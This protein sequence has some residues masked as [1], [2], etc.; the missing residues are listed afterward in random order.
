MGGAG[1]WVEECPIAITVTDAEGAIVEMNAAAREVFSAQGGGGLVG[2]NV[3]DCHP[4]PARSTLV[5]LFAKRTPNHYTIA[6]DG[7][8]KIIH[9]LPWFSAGAFCGFVEISVPIPDELP[10][11]ERG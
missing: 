6:K 1:S 8:R 2:S 3:F 4:E 7:R 10:H 5:E 11:F 9:Q